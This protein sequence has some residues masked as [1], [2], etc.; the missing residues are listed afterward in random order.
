MPGE[1]SSAVTAIDGCQMARKGKAGAAL[2]ITAI[3]FFFA[4]TV[5]TFLVAFF[6]LIGYALVKLRCEPGPLLLG[7][8]LGSLLEEKLRRAMILSRGDATSFVTCPIS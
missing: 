5:S 6:G 8:V 2:A 4:G 1:P 3:G 7:F